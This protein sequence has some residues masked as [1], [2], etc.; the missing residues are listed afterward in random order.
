LITA[1]TITDEQIFR[2]RDHALATGNA[3]LARDCDLALCLVDTHLSPARSIAARAICASIL[4]AR[5]K[6]QP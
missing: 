6:A 1:D 4:N 5:A 3:Q 2:L